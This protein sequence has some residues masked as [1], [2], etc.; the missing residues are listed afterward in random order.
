METTW[1]NAAIEGLANPLPESTEVVIVGAGITGLTLAH[2]LMDAGQS[3]IVLEADAPGAG[4]TGHSS[5]HLI[6]LFDSGYAQIKGELDDCLLSDNAE[7]YQFFR[8][9]EGVS[10]KPILLV[11][12]ANHPA[13]K[14][15]SD[16]RPEDLL[17]EWVAPH[18]D[19]VTKEAAWSA[20]YY[21]SADGLPSIGPSLRNGSIY[22]ATGCNGDGL[23]WDCPCHGGRFAPDGKPLEGPL[24]EGLSQKGSAS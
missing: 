22:I 14:Y 9:V 2:Y 20:Q 5:A 16:H 6:A 15:P 1:A 23:T 18:F 11:G 10:G 21:A 7:P 13:G 8:R 24:T 4:T 17:D 3:P 19:V 12:G